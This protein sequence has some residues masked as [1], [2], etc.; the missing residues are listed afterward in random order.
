MNLFQKHEGFGWY[1][2][3]TFSEIYF[4]DSWKQLYDAADALSKFIKNTD[5]F[6]FWKLNDKIDQTGLA[7][8]F[9]KFVLKFCY[10]NDL[11]Y[12]IYHHQ[13]LKYL[14]WVEEW[15]NRCHIWVKNYITKENYS[16]FSFS[17]WVFLLLSIFLKK[18][19]AIVK[20]NITF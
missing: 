2:S 10:L 4:M 14:S 20:E 18:H 7:N 8:S 12:S 17:F 16:R 19:S 11:F 5:I 1:R 6:N 9:K 3:K 13:I 15:F